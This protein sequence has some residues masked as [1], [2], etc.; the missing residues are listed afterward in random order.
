M[1]RP[2]PLK[3]RWKSPYFYLGIILLLA[4]LIRFSFLLEFRQTAFYNASLMT[5]YDQRTFDNWAKD[6][7]K[8]P[9]V[10]N[11]KV[12]YMAPGYPYFVAGIYKMFGS[13]NY[14]AVAFIQILL[15]TLLCLLLFFLG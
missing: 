14:F 11:G 3:N 12:F 13:S 10:G 9:V 8:N 1:S 4:F 15:D 6:I 5:K 2:D 7:V